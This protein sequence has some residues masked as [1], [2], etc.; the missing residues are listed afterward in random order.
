MRNRATAVEWPVSSHV[1]SH[2]LSSHPVP[3]GCDS[4]PMTKSL[5]EEQRCSCIVS[6]VTPSSVG[7]SSCASL[8]A[9][10]LTFASNQHTNTPGILVMW[11]DPRY[12]PKPPLS[13]CS[14]LPLL[15]EGQVGRHVW[16]V[17]LL[18]AVRAPPAVCWHGD[19]WDGW[20]TCVAQRSVGAG[21]S[22]AVRTAAK[23]SGG[24][25]LSPPCSDP[26]CSPSSCKTG[27]RG[28]GFLMSFWS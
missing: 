12:M 1:Q 26:L 20:V 23:Q 2:L 16:W 15:A 3:S 6:C 25:H 27:V 24:L 9:G 5:R 28:F 11:F 13:P 21:V 10:A 18:P 14:L 8:P 19:S 17:Q 4:R 22:L 7:D